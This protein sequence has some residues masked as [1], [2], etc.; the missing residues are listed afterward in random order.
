L[1]TDENILHSVAVEVAAKYITH[2]LKMKQP[3]LLRK[4]DIEKILPTIRKSK[5]LTQIQHT[6]ALDINNLLATIIGQNVEDIH[7]LKDISK[8]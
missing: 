2:E 7:N 4:I 8:F 3:E 1:Y 5:N 6:S